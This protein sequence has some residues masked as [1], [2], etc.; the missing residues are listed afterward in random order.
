MSKSESKQ[1]FF[2]VGLGKTASSYLQ[3]KVFP[4][5]KN[6]EY[7]H[8]N[9]RY[10]RAAKIIAKGKSE[11]YL[12]S[13]EFDIQMERE[14]KKIADVYP[15]TRAIILFRQ[16]DGWIASQYR[17]FVK[18][19][20]TI[21]FNE[22][23]NLKENQGMFKKDNLSFYNYIKILEKHLNPKPIVLFYDDLRKD[24]LAFFDYIARQIGT[25]YNKKDISLKSKHS[26][27]NEQQLKAIM[28]VSKKIDIR[29]HHLKKS[30]YI[31]RRF[32]TNMIR[33][34]T[35]YVSKYLP[36][37]WFSKEP[38]ID[39]VYLKQVRDYYEADYQKVLEYAKKNNP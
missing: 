28:R 33:Y 19:G 3:Y 7:I 18:N 22:F 35:L 21:P 13:R 34:S 6:I 37:S 27:Y 17:R 23:F 12:I 4:Y 11:I 29:R 14:V 16:H 20:Y 25:T 32:Y 5:F 36:G 15:D 24:P 10:H 1:I 39:P 8:R 2:H 31:F 26:S 38:L 30:F 9:P